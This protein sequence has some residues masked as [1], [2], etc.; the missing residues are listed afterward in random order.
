MQLISV[1]MDVRDNYERYW[2]TAH[3]VCEECYPLTRDPK[4]EYRIKLWGTITINANIRNHSFQGIF[5][6]EIYVY[7]WADDPDKYGC[8]WAMDGQFCDACHSL[9]QAH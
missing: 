2:D 6:L 9:T 4:A 7:I 8:D 3:Q 5:S 1:W